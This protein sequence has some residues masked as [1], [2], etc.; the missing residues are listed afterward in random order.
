MCA[1][2]AFRLCQYTHRRQEGAFF[3]STVDSPTG[4]A[5]LPLD[6]ASVLDRL[7][8]MLSSPDSLIVDSAR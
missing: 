3:T 6:V 7:N 5:L 1:L 4:E 8:A 2:I